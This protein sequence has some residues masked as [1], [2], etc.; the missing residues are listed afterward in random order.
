MNSV[1]SRPERGQGREVRKIV[2]KK[3]RL[4]L[5]VKTT[6]FDFERVERNIL[7][8]SL[9]SQSNRQGIIID[10]IEQGGGHIVLIFGLVL[11]KFEVAFFKLQ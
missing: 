9:F 4:R 6:K 10:L 1:R 11:L 3:S 7:L 2:D 8:D 5:K